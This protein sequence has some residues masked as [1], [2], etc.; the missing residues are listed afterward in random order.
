MDD[1]ATL[2]APILGPLHVSL[3]PSQRASVTFRTGGS[4]DRQRPT[5]RHT[6]VR[7]APPD[8]QSALGLGGQVERWVDVA[9][10]GRGHAGAHGSVGPSRVGGYK[11]QRYQDRFTVM[12][13]LIR[14]PTSNGMR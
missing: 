3:C 11:L 6:A 10:G 2:A 4:F 13:A 9:G 1:G 7:Y 8:H 14:D 5:H 12:I